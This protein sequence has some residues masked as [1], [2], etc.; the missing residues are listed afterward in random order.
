MKV[1][2]ITGGIGSGKSTAASIMARHG[3]KIIDADI[4][5]RRLMRKNGKTYTDVVKEFGTQILCENG[6]INR[7]A[8]AAIVFKDRERLQKLTDITHR[9]ILPAMLRALVRIKKSGFEGIV[10]IDAPIPV[11]HGFLDL[12]DEVW[13]VTAP[14]EARISRIIKRGGI[15]EE[16]ARRRMSMQMSEDEYKDIADR[17]IAN[18]GSEDELEKILIHISNNLP[19]K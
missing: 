15:S 4:I 7:K 2:G 6:D 19:T 17:V 9:H 10:V 11:K 18:D 12:V 14:A 1:I 8:L 13:V 3:A 16:E 5:S